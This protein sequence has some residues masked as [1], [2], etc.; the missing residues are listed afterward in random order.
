MLSILA[1]STYS[2]A[3]LFRPAGAVMMEDKGVHCY[4]CKR[5]F[6]SIPKFLEHIFSAMH[7]GVSTSGGGSGSGVPA[8][9]MHSAGLP[10][11][12]ENK[13]LFPQ[14]PQPQ[15]C[16]EERQWKGPVQEPRRSER[17]P[18]NFQRSPQE[19]QGLYWSSQ[20]S[21]WPPRPE[22]SSLPES[23]PQKPQQSERPTW[24]QQ[25]R[26]R[27]PPQPLRQTQSPLQR[28]PASISQDQRTAGSSDR[29]RDGRHRD[30]GSGILRGSYTS[31]SPSRRMH[32]Y[33]RAST[34]GPSSSTSNMA[35]PVLPR[36]SAPQ[37]DKPIMKKT[38][39]PQESSA[40]PVAKPKPTAQKNAAVEPEPGLQPPQ[41]AATAHEF[42]GKCDRYYINKRFRAEHLR[43]C[44][45]GKVSRLIAAGNQSISTYAQRTKTGKLFGCDE[46]HVLFRS[47]AETDLHVCK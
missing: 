31:H 10:A 27:S 34:V 21:E 45:T 30:G 1:L 12:V 9:S 13:P 44:G 40:K 6:I 46:C 15:S 43:I 5:D 36:A 33:Q 22:H 35:P 3:W 17:P 24:P 41:R 37:T 18:Q 47:R 28:G 8:N 19:P 42:C 16:S 32:P 2:L 38:P 7:D 20:R 29:D 39:A 14:Q 25:Q 23:L 26:K 11:A 4:T